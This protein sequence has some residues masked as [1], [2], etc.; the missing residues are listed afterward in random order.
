MSELTIDTTLAIKKEDLTTLISL[1]QKKG[2]K[3][4]GPT[5]K[6]NALVLTDVNKLEDFPIG[7]S[8]VQ[9]KGSFRLKQNLNKQYFGFTTGHDSWKQFLF[10]PQCVLFD[11]SKDNGHWKETLEMEDD[12]KQAF[13]GVRPC[14]LAAIT[15]Q[16]NVFIRDDFTDPIYKAKRQN[17]LIISVSCS[18]PAPTCFCSSMGTGPKAETGFD[19]NLIELDNLFLVEVGSDAGLSLMREIPWELAS[20]YHLQTSNQ[21]NLD[22]QN[23]IQRKM[24]DLKN[25]PEMLINNLGSPMWEQISE[26]CLNC[27]SCTQVCPTCF[28]WDMVDNT[29]LPGNK[30]E[31]VR[32]WD[33]C[34]NPTYS[35]Q[36]GGNIRA[37]TMPRY[38]QWLTHKFSTWINQFG[39]LGCTGCGRCIVW[40]P[41]KI[42]IT[43]NISKL[44][45]ALA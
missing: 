42:D 16:D 32:I 20:A 27:G 21:I 2:Y 36:A 38:R 18:D 15:I 5:I 43:E 30:T 3:T 19:L 17:L 4:I 11:S 28:C 45:E 9:E 23:S 41:A 13:I 35:A 44:Q 1:L 24:E 12:Q 31:R 29:N 33:S 10:P 37:T 34:F 6:E 7:Y 26:N 22:S 40:C 8:T 25:L 14:D 39:S